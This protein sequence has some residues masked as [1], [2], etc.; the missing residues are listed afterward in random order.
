MSKKKKKFK[1]KFKAQILNNLDKIENT[2]TEETKV[3]P[4]APLKEAKRVLEPAKKAEAKEEKITP[5]K[6]EIKY[7][8]ADLKRLAVSV[9]IIFVLF[10]VVI[11]LNSQTTILKNFS[12]ELVNWA[13]INR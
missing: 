2:Q 12:S 9:G 4:T 5:D 1:K 10:M 13:H 3:A 7:F 11:V 8:K 6:N